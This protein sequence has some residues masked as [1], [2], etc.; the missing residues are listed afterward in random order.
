MRNVLLFF[1]YAVQR[2]VKR[3]ERTEKYHFFFIFWHVFFFF[4]VIVLEY[5][6][7]FWGFLTTVFGCAGF[8]CS[9][10]RIGNLELKFLLEIPIVVGGWVRKHIFRALYICR[11]LIWY[12]F[13][14]SVRNFPLRFVRIFQNKYIRYIFYVRLCQLRSNRIAARMYK[15]AGRKKSTNIKTE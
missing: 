5:C 15:A 10:Q 8:A 12:I 11:S 6:K 13:L 1:Y 2:M 7:W 9:L 3:R 4:L 14:I